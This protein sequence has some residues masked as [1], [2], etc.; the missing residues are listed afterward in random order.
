MA[1]EW[2]WLIS[3]LNGCGAWDCQGSGGRSDF[4]GCDCALALGRIL[5]RRSNSRSHFTKNLMLGRTFK[6]WCL[7]GFWPG[8]VLD[9][10]LKGLLLGLTFLSGVDLHCKR[11]S[12]YSHLKGPVFNRAF[13]GQMH[14]HISNGLMLKWT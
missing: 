14:N 8:L 2:L 13:T 12:A 9:R 7:V 10:N 1:H 5:L 3:K 6:V 4:Q 11:S